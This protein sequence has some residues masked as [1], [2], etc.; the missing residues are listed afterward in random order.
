MAKRDSTFRK[1]VLE[2]DYHECIK[3]GYNGEDLEARPLLEADHARERG[4]GGIP[5]R[6]EIANG[7][8]LCAKCH[9]EKTDKL[10]FIKHWDR[11]NKANGLL[12]RDRDGNQ[13]P[14]K[15]LWFYLRQEREKVKEESGLLTS[16]SL[17]AG[18][19]AMMFHHVFQYCSLLKTG[20]TPDEYIAGLGLDSVKAREEAD[21][22][23]WVVENGLTWPD[24]VNASKVALIRSVMEQPR[25][26]TAQ[27]RP[28]SVWNGQWQWWLE[29]ARSASYSVLEAD[30][31]KEGWLKGGTMKEDLYLQ[32]PVETANWFYRASLEGIPRKDG[33]YLVRVGKVFPPLR[34]VR[35]RL[36]ARDGLIEREIEIEHGDE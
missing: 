4:M 30:L 29:K 14:K 15:D 26:P 9:R 31:V 17:T 22:A 1:A 34:R 10:W 28:S 20:Q 23:G 13:I 27:E 25:P 11:T 35:G 12:I 24:G 19:R 8:A 21:L 7:G 6:D 2:A 32:V 3:C 5:S 16:L 33:Y 36:L 18:A